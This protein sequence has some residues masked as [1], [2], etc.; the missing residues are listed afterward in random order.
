MAVPQQEVDDMKK[1]LMLV[2]AIAGAIV[3]ALSAGQIAAARS[4]EA[5]KR[6]DHAFG[7]GTF[8]PGCWQ[9]HG[10]PFCVPY[11]YTARILGVQRGHGH[12][13]WGEFERRNHG[14]GG[15]FSGS[16]TCTNVSGNRAAI[17]GFLT[18]T[19][20]GPGVG[21]GDPFIVYVADNGPLASEARD[22]I[23]AL[24]VLPAGDPDRPLMPARFPRTCPSADSIYGYLPLATGDITVSESRVDWDDS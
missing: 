17:G 4:D 21:A 19:P 9:T 6:R 3:A 2:A 15:V 8:G 20:G 11:S 23:S 24:A 14:T 5:P 13:A 7:A 16:V 1:R 22:E 10:G 18:Q 12:R